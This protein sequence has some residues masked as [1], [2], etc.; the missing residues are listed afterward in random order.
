MAFGKWREMGN[1]G[2]AMGKRFQNG[3]KWGGIG[4]FNP[5]WGVL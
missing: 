2:E 5:T 4:V 3:R 1:W